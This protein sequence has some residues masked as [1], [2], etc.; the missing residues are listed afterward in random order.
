MGLWLR[1]VLDDLAATVF[2]SECHVCEGPLLR[3]GRTPVC[4]ACLRAVRPQRERLCRTCGEAL[5]MESARFAEGFGAE[6]G[7]CTPCRR[8]PPAFTQAAAFGVYE[9]ELRELIHLLKYEGKRGLARPLGAML[10]AA[11]EPMGEAISPERELLV[12]AV[13]LFRAKQRGRGFN[14]AELLANEAVRSLRG[15]RPAWRMR[16]AH[17]VL[18]RARETE[19]QFGLTPRAGATTCAVRLRCRTRRGWRGAMCC[20]WTIST[21]PGRRHGRVR[22]CCGVPARAAFWWGRWRER[23]WSRSRCGMRAPSRDGK[24]SSLGSL[25]KQ[26]EVDS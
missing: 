19:S 15:S 18:V 6:A 25:R 14:H 12:V 2:P 16:A 24:A 10:A 8:V 21:P 7:V 20:C 26:A 23:R 17:D 22:R 3:A 11:V 4:E 1:G 5:G 9:A 13:P